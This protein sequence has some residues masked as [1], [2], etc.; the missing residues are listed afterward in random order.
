[1]GAEPVDLGWALEGYPLQTLAGVSGEVVLSDLAPGAYVVEFAMP[2]GCG[3]L[4]DGF[5]ITDPEVLQVNVV[6]ASDASCP[7]S[8]DGVVE[9]AMSGGEAPYYQ[10]WSTGATGP[11]LVAGPGTYSVELGDAR[12]CSLLLTDVVIG[13]GEGPVAG[14]AAETSVVVNT[15]VSFTSTSAP[16]DGW[17]WDFGDGAT[18]SA[19]APVHTYTLPGT[20]T[21]TL[22]ATF[23][24][25][26][27]T[28]TTEVTVEQNVGLTTLADGVELNA[29]ATAEHILLVHDLDGPLH[30]ELLDA[31]G[32]LHRA[33]TSAAGPG[34]LRLPCEG[35]AD[36]L[37]FVRVTHAG[38][39][40]TLR[41]PLV[42]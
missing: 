42:R 9:F 35:L 20:H 12:G 38:V 28:V 3:T 41:V 33:Y 19:E 30:V 25:C 23:G 11:V 21:V 7:N 4:L 2:G 1:V 31:N 39:Q 29:M 17:H 24:D 37:W 8:T 27:D 16:A 14:I 22:V 32:R 40:R 5:T 36:G 6:G 18:S 13:A 15:P 26:S 10:L 34:T